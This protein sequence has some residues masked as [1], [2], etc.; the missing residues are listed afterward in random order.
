MPE[1]QADDFILPFTV[2]GADVRGRVVRFGPLVDQV[3]TRHAYPEPM[4]QLLGEALALAALLGSALKFEGI[5]SLQTKGDGPVSMLLADYV[6]GGDTGAGVLRGYAAFDRK[7]DFS[8][9]EKGFAALTGKGYLALTVDQNTDGERYQG[10]VPLEG[11][12]LAACAESYF[13]ISEQIPTSIALSVGQLFSRSGQ[14]QGPLAENRLWRAGGMLI[15][16][17]PKTVAA[18]R[19]PED[20]LAETD[21]WRRCRLLMATLRPDELIDTALGAE[22]VLYRLFNEDGVR[23]FPKTAARFGCRCDRGRL[24]RVL[25]QYPRD[26][27]EPMLSDGFILANCEFC[28][29]TYR[30][31][32]DELAANTQTDNTHAT[33]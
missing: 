4:S 11:E 29:E 31:T 15:Q 32:L 24:E 33:S 25:L 14:H 12:N 13:R 7:A 1:T 28:N 19:A 23:V 22:A 9:L 18:S 16:H 17:L 20:P 26:T 10:I 8:Q 2:E 30:F 3:L 5:F 6:A 27:L 21:A